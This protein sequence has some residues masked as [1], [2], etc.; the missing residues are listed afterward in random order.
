MNFTVKNA[1][2]LPPFFISSI[3]NMVKEMERS[4]NPGESPTFRKGQLGNWREEFDQEIKQAFK[5][6]AG[7]ILIQLGYEKDDKW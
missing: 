5:H 1:D 6:V 4:I 7:D 3:P 2:R